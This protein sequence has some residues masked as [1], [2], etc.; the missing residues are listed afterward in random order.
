MPDEEHEVDEEGRDVYKKS[1]TND[2]LVRP[3]AAMEPREGLGTPK[4]NITERFVVEK[5]GTLKEDEKTVEFI[6]GE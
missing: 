5:D 3:S 4:Y 1:A 2:N 6:V